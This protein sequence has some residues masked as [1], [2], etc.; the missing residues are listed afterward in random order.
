MMGGVLFKELNNLIWKVES[1]E[2]FFLINYENIVEKRQ[3][4]GRGRA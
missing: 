2:M 1:I 4:K 3:K